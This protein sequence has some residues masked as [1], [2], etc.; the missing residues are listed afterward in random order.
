MQKGIGLDCPV[1]VMSSN[2]SFPETK[3]WNNEY[4]SSDI[5]LDIH[6][7]QKYGQKL[8]NYVTRDTIQN[9]I[10]DLILSEKTRAT[11]Y[12]AQCSTGCRENKH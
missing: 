9:G 5:V 3:E 8:G 7:I 6:D 4:L 10:H 11:M 2:K 1:L 12:I